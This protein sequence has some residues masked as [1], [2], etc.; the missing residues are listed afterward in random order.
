MKVELSE[1]PADGEPAGIVPETGLPAS[2]RR[3]RRLP[4]AI[5]AVCALVAVAV[6]VFLVHGRSLDPAHVA[7]QIAEMQ[8]LADEDKTVVTPSP[9][10]G[11]TNVDV[12]AD[13]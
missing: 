12:G 7:R 4:S 8:G 13:A 1:W 11:H 2:P 6:I 10:G 3:R 5:V 9:E